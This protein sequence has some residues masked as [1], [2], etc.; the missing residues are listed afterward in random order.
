MNIIEQ[1][2]KDNNFGRVVGMEFKIVEPGIV[3]YFLTINETHLSTPRA[4]HGGVI[5]AMMDGVLGV[6]ALSKTVLENRIVS[7]VEF[8][9]NYLAPSLLGDELFGVGK[10][11]NAGKRLIIT[12][13]DI[14][15]TNRNNIV[16]AKAMGTFNA[17][18]VEKA[19]YVVD[20]KK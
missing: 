19:G 17:Y 18:P 10:I 20:L 9:I 11:E 8:K 3:H 14:M 6:A 13:G 12:S 15:C 1:Y 5:A 2:I 16:I 7:T 4:T